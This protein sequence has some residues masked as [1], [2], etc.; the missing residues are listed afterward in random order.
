MMESA[1]A[2]FPGTIL[3]VIM[4]GM[5]NDGMNGIEMVHEKG[6]ITLAQDEESCVVYGMPK[7]CVEKGIIDRVVPLAHMAEVM[8]EFAG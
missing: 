1:A 8:N 2:A 5:G 7:V 6:G 3:G 4:T